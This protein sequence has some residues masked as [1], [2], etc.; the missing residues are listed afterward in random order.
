MRLEDYLESLGIRGDQLTKECD[1]P[2]ELEIFHLSHFELFSQGVQLLVGQLEKILL[3]IGVQLHLLTQLRVVVVPYAL[4]FEFVPQELDDQVKGV[5][6]QAIV[7]DP[8][9]DV[10]TQYFLALPLPDF[11]A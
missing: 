3:K 1:L 7:A 2:D 10:V 9:R 11:L 6:K 8:F 5:Q 4:L